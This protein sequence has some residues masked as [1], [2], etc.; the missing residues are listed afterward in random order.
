MLQCIAILMGI[1]QALIVSLLTSSGWSVILVSPVSITG[2]I[3]LSFWSVPLGNTVTVTK[4]YIITQSCLYMYV[5]TLDNR[6]YIYASYSCMYIHVAHVPGA[7]VMNKLQ[8]QHTQ[9]GVCVTTKQTVKYH[10]LK[11]DYNAVLAKV[12]TI[13]NLLLVYTNT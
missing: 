9:L 6:L 7:D 13:I 10:L 11:S 8:S 12:T 3:T 1:D 4:V 2:A 5:S